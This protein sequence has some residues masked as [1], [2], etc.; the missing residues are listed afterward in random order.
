MRLEWPFSARWRGWRKKCSGRDRPRLLDRLTGSFVDRTA[1]DWSALLTRVVPAADRAFVENLRQIDQLRSSVRSRATP[2]TGEPPAIAWLVAVL[3]IVHTVVSLAIVLVTEVPSPAPPLHF[4]RITLAMTFIAA[5][6]L[7]AATAARD[8]RRALLLATLACAASAFARGALTAV[9]PT[10]FGP[11]LRSLWL[12]VFLP[13]CLWQFAMDFPRVTRFTRFDRLARRATGVAWIFGTMVFCLNAGVAADVIDEAQVAAV[14]PNHP[15]NLFWQVFTAIV[16]LAVATIVIRSR[17]APIAE[18]RRV[19][20]LAYALAFGTGPFLLTGVLRSVVPSFDVW[21]MTAAAAGRIWSDVLV[22]V[23]LAAMPLLSALAVIVD[24]PFERQASVGRFLSIR[25]PLRLPRTVNQVSALAETLAR[26]RSARTRREIC[27][28]AID[29]VRERLGSAEVRI[30]VPGFD[31]RYSDAF[32]DTHLRAD[33]ALALII[34]EAAGPLL[35]YRD[36]SS[37]QLLPP[38]DR[39]WLAAIGVELV[40]PI[41][42]RDDSLVAVVACSQ[43]RDGRRFSRR[44]LSLLNAITVAVSASWDTTGVGN[45][46]AFECPRC[47]IVSAT[48]AL[49][50]RCCRIVTLAALPH[51]LGEQFVVRRRIGRGGMGVVYL[52][53]DIVHERDVALKT[54]PRLDPGAA[55]RLR[56]EARAMANL[57]HEAL[58][59]IHAYS[60]WQDAPVLVVEYFPQGTLA[61]RLRAG[62]LSSAEA[63]YLMYR[64]ADALVYLHDRGVRH[65]DLKPANIALDAQNRPHLLDFG[66][67][68][69]LER[70]WAGRICGTIPYLP[71]EAFRGAQPS[72][73]FDL[74]ALGVVAVEALSGAHPFAARNQRAT[75]RRILDVTPREIA[76][77]VSDLDTSWNT[78][79]ERALAPEPERRFQTARELRAAL[80]ARDVDTPPG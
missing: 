24:R 20:R 67:T 14:L 11:A 62:P 71:P 55:G 69:L 78:F 2:D 51:R 37:T 73:L 46:A 60:T 32:G 74:W 3:A 80:S 21:L 59:T 17:R 41:K 79:F 29:F 12:D 27:S 25:P 57:D 9:P 34:R 47:G 30:L 18:R 45:D 13:A 36:G 68:T 38:V 7:L 5:C 76:S 15:S 54:V 31:G 16:L 23:P 6:V 53:R 56:D 63:L 22:L 61:G 52:A 1:I 33:S 75:V 43:R 64:L 28:I 58:A 48:L 35:L 77:R 40:A 44:D 42:R 4:V 26:I 66:L 39:E 65:G 49:P 19:R 72:S 8:P 70:G 10:P 50:C